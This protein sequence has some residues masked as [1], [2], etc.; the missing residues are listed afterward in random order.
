MPDF[1]LLLVQV[2]GG[3]TLVLTILIKVVGFPD[4]IRQNYRR[5][6]TEGVSSRLYLLSFLTYLFWTLHGILQKD[7][8]VVLG[9]SLGVLTS[10][11]ILY[12]IVAYRRRGAKLN[13]RA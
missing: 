13:Q 10:G 3:I 4:Q 5:K 1:S 8:V 11:I 12:Q 2:V 9:Q 6:S 7:I